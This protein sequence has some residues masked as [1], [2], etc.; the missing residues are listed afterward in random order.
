MSKLVRYI[1][2]SIGSKQVIGIAGLCLCLFLF[3][4]MVGNLWM[5]H[6]AKAYNMYAYMLKSNSLLV[7][8]E[9]GLVFLFFLH[10][11]FSLY[12]SYRN[13]KLKG[14]SY[15]EL[16]KTD[17]K[18]SF[19]SKTLWCQGVIIFIFVITHLFTFYDGPYYEVIYDGKT[20][21]DLFRLLV[22]VF[23]DPFYVTGYVV[24]LLVLGFHLG[25]GFVSS[26]QTLGFS[27]YKKCLNKIGLL[28]TLIVTVGFITQP[29][30]IYFFYK[31]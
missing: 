19:V 6:S 13:H 24:A 14:E 26:F 4:H 29:L 7:L 23:K 16:S 18:T 27:H 9:L 25:H 22:E 10:V 21:R 20:V 31:G 28:Y 3:V 11:S 12:I 15:T 2:S 8:A 17:K 1:F 30:Y 5:F